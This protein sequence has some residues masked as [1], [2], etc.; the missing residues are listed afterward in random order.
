MHTPQRSDFVGFD[1]LTSWL[2]GAGVVGPLLFIVVFL[3]EGATR[4]GY[5]VWRNYVSELALSDQGWEQIVNFIVC[6][7]L[8]IGFAF[9]L[10]R[11]WRAGPASRWGPLLIG[12]FGL[13]LIV[14][15]VFVTDPARG[16]PPGAPLTGSPQTF[17]GAVHGVNALIAF[18]ALGAAIFVVARRF[19][20]EPG[21]RGWATY[22]RVIGVIFLLLFPISTISGT[23]AEHN[24]LSVP[25]GILQRL[26]IIL[27]WTWLS[28]TAYRLL[29][30]QRRSLT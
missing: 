7:S 28:L 16:Y 20:A 8:S 12:L 26:E 3:V 2:L 22:S 18:P 23:L 4:P 5:S 27:G 6:G 9:G 29:R 21:Q 1:R 19:A 24:L 11:I 10:R 30:E 14:A 25:T 17:H 13:S 15:G